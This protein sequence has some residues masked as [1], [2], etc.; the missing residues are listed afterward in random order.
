[1]QYRHV[2]GI[3]LKYFSNFEDAFDDLYDSMSDV[4]VS[5]LYYLPYQL[6][7]FGIEMHPNSDAAIE[8]PY[9]SEVKDRGDDTRVLLLVV[10]TGV[11]N[12]YVVSSLRELIQR[13]IS[14]V[15]A[16]LGIG[17]E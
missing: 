3:T 4:Y 9:T 6:K 13:R 8:V 2:G 5:E 17:V 16:E 7:P 15:N 11:V 10:R 14:R 12:E 1:M